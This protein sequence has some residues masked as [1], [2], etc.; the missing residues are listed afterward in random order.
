MSQVSRREVLAG[1]CGIAALS[2]PD[3]NRLEVAVEDVDEFGPRGT[4]QS[5]SL[6]SRSYDKI[7]Q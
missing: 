2:G 6:D 4:L 3:R 5:P 1:V 7:R